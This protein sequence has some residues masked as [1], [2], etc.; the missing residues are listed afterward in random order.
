[1]SVLQSK[2]TTSRTEFINTAKDIY[3]ETLTFLTK[4]S[5]KYSRLIA[6]RI[7]DLAG[8]AL[9][10]CEKANQ[11][12]PSGEDNKR[13][14]KE[15]LVTARATLMALDVRLTLCYELM[16]RNPQGCFEKE[17]SAST[18]KEKISKMA[19]KLGTLIDKEKNLITA[20]IESDRKRK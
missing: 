2:R 13:I 17:I 16:N 5:T 20:V 3:I 19:D 1:M 18:A 15:M 9:D 11:I 7:A 12:Y 8:E 14:R 10:L 4:L 6:G